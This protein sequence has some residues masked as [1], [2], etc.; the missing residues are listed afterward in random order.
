MHGHA[1]AQ[2][3]QDGTPRGLGYLPL[4]G[5]VFPAIENRPVGAPQFDVAVIRGLVEAGP[6]QGVDGLVQQ[7]CGGVDVQAA[8]LDPR[9]AVLNDQVP[10]PRR[11][12][13]VLIE[14]F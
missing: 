9:K 1:T 8:R 5:E 2:S 13:I 14:H 4:V 12:T 3:L 10:R 6:S 11:E 7:L